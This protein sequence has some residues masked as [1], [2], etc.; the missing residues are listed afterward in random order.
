MVVVPHR[1][2]GQQQFLQRPVPEPGTGLTET[3]TWALGRECPVV[4]GT[5]VTAPLLQAF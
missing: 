5:W 3:C 1:A 2:G 4:C